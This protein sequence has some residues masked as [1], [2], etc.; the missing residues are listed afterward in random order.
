MDND[1]TVYDTNSSRVTGDFNNTGVSL[2]A[3]YGRKNALQNG[4]YIEPQAQFTLGYLGGDSYTTSN[5]IE[6]IQ[7]GIKV[8]LDALALILVK[9]L[10]I[11]V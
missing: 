7:S 6:A 11:M 8:L 1:F 10:G 4:W 2:S 5:G 9:N 3:E